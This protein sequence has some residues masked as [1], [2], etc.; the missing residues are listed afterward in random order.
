MATR[1]NEIDTE[2]YL[3]A[4]IEETVS[5]RLPFGSPIVRQGDEK[6]V[7]R[8]ITSFSSTEIFSKRRKIYT[9]FE[10]K[11]ELLADGMPEASHCQ[12]S[13]HGCGIS[14]IIKV[15]RVFSCLDV[16]VSLKA[17]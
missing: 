5:F 11:P 14:N 6:L 9:C 8:L 15:Q 10:G 3:V 4:V 17:S 16:F 7:Y 12:Q 1:R 13:W 2:L